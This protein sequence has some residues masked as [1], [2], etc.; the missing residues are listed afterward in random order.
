MTGLLMIFM[1]YMTMQQK[2]SFD[3]FLKNKAFHALLI[4][5]LCIAIDWYVAF[6][7]VKMLIH[8]E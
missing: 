3:S 2:D 8:I 1:M 7:F 4:S 6:Q 5:A